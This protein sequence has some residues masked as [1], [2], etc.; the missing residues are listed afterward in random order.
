MTLATEI[1][2]YQA[3]FRAKVPAD[4]QGTMGKATQDL[5][6]SG[7]IDRTLKVGD[8][9]PAVTLPDATGQSFSVQAALEQGPVV[10]AFYRGGWCPYCNLEL[11]ALQ[12]VLPDIQAAGA[13]L[14]AIAPETPDNS[15]STQ[16]KNALTFAV[17]SDVGN[18]VSREFGL[19]FQL[20]ETLRPIYKGFG[21]DIEA[22]NGDQTFELPVPATYVVAPSGEIVYAFAD[23]DYTKRAEPADVVAALKQIA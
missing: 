4:V 17:L 22:Y 18:K 20:P 10:L 14:I 1:Q 3:Q 12:A 7:I 23:A 9:I 15:L 21:I 13:I 2:D 19:V 11:K 5:A 8:R 16:E 6:N